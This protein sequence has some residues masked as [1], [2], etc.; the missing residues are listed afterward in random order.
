MSSSSATDNTEAFYEIA[1]VRTAATS[2][3]FVLGCCFVPFV[4]L[5]TMN[6]A[7]YRYGASD[8]AFYIPAI[9]ESID[10]GLFPRDSDLIRSQARLTFAD[11]VIGPFA[12]MTGISLPPL[13]AGLQIAALALLALAAM[14]I[15]SVLYRTLW[16]S[17]GLLAAL[18]LRHAISKS[19]TN[20]LEGY[21]HPRQ[22]SFAIGALAIAAF[23]RGQNAATVVLVVA[24]GALHPTTGLWFAI[25]LGVAMFVAEPRRRGVIATVAAI[26]TVL[27][28]WA[29]S[30][31]PL[32][33]RITPMDDE[34]LATL[35]A[36][37][38][39]FPLNWPIVTWVVNLGY[40]PLIVLLYRRRRAAGVVDDR[41][42]AL[43][44]GCL[45]LAAVF[46]VSLP[47]NA[48]H[49]A[50][51]IQLQPARIFWM[52]DFLAVVYVV[53]AAAEG[54]TP[55]AARARAVALGLAL[56]SVVRGAYVMFVEFPDRRLAQIGVS[57]DDWGR[58]MA[59]ARGSEPGSGWL[60]E[61][62]HAARYGTSV[63]VA[64]ERDVFVE[65][66]KDGAVGMYD[67]SVALRTRN[68]VQVLGDFRALTPDHAR[69]LATQYDLDY[70][71]TEQAID[72][73]RVFTSGALSIYRLRPLTRMPN[74][75]P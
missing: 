26:C 11:D 64:A 53:W 5:A 30:A 22:L 10:A 69:A 27:G 52:L 56:V 15:G 1:L 65:A 68:R 23:L 67:R 45:T 71:V 21:F 39:L 4:L 46:L 25:W 19:G 3:S 2:V 47:F 44:A 41:E 34:W 16:T 36:K 60:A 66:I 63:R 59:W 28:L 49:L 61:P 70:L 24:A 8:Q 13:F 72:L 58:A 57:D 75:E 43:V 33:G 7:G 14:R 12:R 38:Y 9:L 50:L 31:G 73:P 55:N 32:A 42:P 6:S 17:L 18:T 35:A 20:T 74:Q 29:L 40:V 54:L 48:A 37:D 62:D 51:A